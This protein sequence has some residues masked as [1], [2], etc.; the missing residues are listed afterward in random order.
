M[1]TETAEQLNS[2]R[3][4]R[5]RWTK[6]AVLQEQLGQIMAEIFTLNGED[7]EAVENAA[8]THREHAAGCRDV[9]ATYDELIREVERMHA[10]LN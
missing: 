7:G 5:E 4:L 3:Q 1:S 10:G 8:K 6:A 9:A 2:A